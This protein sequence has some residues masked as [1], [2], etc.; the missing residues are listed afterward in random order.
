MDAMFTRW[1]HVFHL[2]TESEQVRYLL[3]CI[4]R[5]KRDPSAVRA[6]LNDLVVCSGA[7]RIA[8]SDRGR[9]GGLRRAS[10][11]RNRSLR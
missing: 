7:L 4:E 10:I 1:D 5:G 8:S 2:D 9:L 3:T 11:R 6:A